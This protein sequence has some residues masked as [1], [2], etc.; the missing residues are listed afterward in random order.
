MLFSQFQC[1]PLCPL[2]FVGDP[3]QFYA[4]PILC[5][6]PTT[7]KTKLGAPQQISG[8]LRRTLCP[9]FQIRVSAY[10]GICRA[11]AY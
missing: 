1:F 11:T 6:V 3:L 5:F 7:H 2:N 9:Q 8:G 4:A 10:D